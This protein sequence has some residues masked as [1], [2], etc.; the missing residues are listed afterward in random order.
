MKRHVNILVEREREGR[1]RRKKERKKMRKKE[2]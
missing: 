1:E 2:R